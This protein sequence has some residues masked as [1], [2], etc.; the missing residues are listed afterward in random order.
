MSKPP[1]V[2][3]STSALPTEQ[4]RPVAPLDLA[5]KSLTLYLN[6]KFALFAMT[7]QPWLT[8]NL[9][10]ASSVCHGA[11]PKAEPELQLS[12]AYPSVPSLT[13]ALLVQ[14]ALLRCLGRAPQPLSWVPAQVCWGCAAVQA[15]GDTEQPQGASVAPL[16]CSPLSDTR[17]AVRLHHGN[18]MNDPKP[19]KAR[20]NIF[21]GSANF[22]AFGIPSVN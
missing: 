9:A 19:S 15:A 22:P 17:C 21:Y 5:T 1:W 7:V 20:G 4:K 2:A 12:R 16:A 11:R 14:P 3:C 8:L 18:P 10:S 13:G 6:M